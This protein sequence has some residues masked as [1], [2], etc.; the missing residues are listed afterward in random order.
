MRW[1]PP[2]PAPAWQ[3]QIAA[4]IDSLATLM[5]AVDA[6]LGATIQPWA[7]T[8]RIAD[9]AARF[10]SRARSS[11][12]SAVRRSLLCSLSDD[13]LSPA[14]LAVRV[15]LG[16]CARELVSSGPARRPTEPG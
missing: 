2:S 4:E 1:K 11:T 7:A 5:E 6:G 14:A 13:E 3:P 9:A 8:R 16:A 12:P 10:R 15:V